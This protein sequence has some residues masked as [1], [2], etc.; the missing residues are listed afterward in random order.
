M[1]YKSFVFTGWC[2][3]LCRLTSEDIKAPGGW[4]L[5]SH[6][7]WRHLTS[8]GVAWRH[9]L[10]SRVRI[11]ISD[12][13]WWCNDQTTLL[14]PLV[15]PLNSDLQ[16][17]VSATCR[18]GRYDYLITSLVPKWLYAT[19]KIVTLWLSDSRI[20][21]P[22]FEPKNESLD[23][24]SC[25]GVNYLDKPRTLYRRVKENTLIHALLPHPRVIICTS[26]ISS[27]D[28]AVLSYYN[29]T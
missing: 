13:P 21:E 7:S 24:W 18:G 3:R 6:R 9:H 15:D 28:C 14:S 17:V 4:F 1:F 29:A 19:L 11:I 20:A 16:R 27:M 23:V 25:L 2:G 22:C 10:G 26:F 5:L 12:C 8:K